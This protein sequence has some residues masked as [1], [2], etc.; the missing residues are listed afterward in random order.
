MINLTQK[1]SN[2]SPK[3]LR[4]RIELCQDWSLSM[5]EFSNHAAQAHA[6]QAH[7]QADLA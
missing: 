2:F 7:S 5:R 1:F 6:A 3:I 4:N